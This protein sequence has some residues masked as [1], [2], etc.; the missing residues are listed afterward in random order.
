[1]TSGSPDVMI[2]Q[3][4]CLPQI[5]GGATGVNPIWLG[6]EFDS[7][8]GPTDEGGSGHTSSKVLANAEPAVKNA[9]NVEPFTIVSAL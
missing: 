1:M 3:A 5:Q 2:P 6:R 8:A 4:T 9:S 7:P